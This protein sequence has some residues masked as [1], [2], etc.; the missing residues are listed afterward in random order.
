MFDLFPAGARSRLAE[1]EE[2]RKQE[3]SALLDLREEID[4]LLKGGG[5]L[6]AEE[7][8]TPHRFSRPGALAD[9]LGQILDRLK[10]TNEELALAHDE[11]R[12]IFDAAGAAILVLDDQ[13]RL[14]EWNRSGRDLFFP[15]REDARGLTCMHVVCGEQEPPENCLFRRVMVEGRKVE[16]NDFSAAGRH[17]NVAASPIRD[18]EGRISRVVLVY[19]DVAE[20]RR[21]EESLRESEFRFRDLLENASD[22]VQ[23]V[24][25]DGRLLYVNR[26]WRE[27]LGYSEEEVDTLDIFDL[28]HPQSREHCQAAFRQ[29]MEG[30]RFDHL[31]ACFIAR[32]GREV[33]VEGNLNCQL[34][35]GV[36]VATRG[37]FRDVTARRHA[38]AEIR[39]L[40]YFDV[41]TGLPNRTLFR[42]RL[43]Q[44]LARARR[45]NDVVALMFL[46]TDRFK[47]V[48]DSL[49]HEAGDRLLQA[50]GERLSACVRRSDTVARL[51]GDE[52]VII[53]GGIGG[54]HDA[55]GAAQKI[56]RAVSAPITV[57]GREIFLTCS[58]G[59]SLYPNDAGDPEEL[60]KNADLAMY[61]A[62][63]Q[64]N[65][66]QFFTPQMNVQ[67]L[68]RLVM[69]NDLRHALNRHE[70]LLHYQPQI[71]LSTG[72]IIGVEALLRWSHPTLGPV[73]PALF[74]DLAEETGLIVPVGRWVLRTACAQAQAWQ[75]AG[76][77]P[78]VMSVNLSAR[79]FREPD[80]AETV[81][82]TLALTG[83]PPSW[84]ELEITETALMENGERTC[85][86]LQEL[87]TMGV[88]LAVDDFGTGYSSLNYLKH[89]PIDRLKID[90]S[91][92]RDLTVNSE[93]AAI[94]EAIIAL[95]HTLRLRVIAEGVETREQL[96]FLREHRCD[97]M[98]GFYFCRP[99]TQEV[100]SNM[101]AQGLVCSD[102]CPI[103]PR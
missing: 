52:F 48:N 1:S 44:E 94:A 10:R 45:E 22:L 47:E 39:R 32:D 60:V 61:Q 92:V 63:G 59:I 4:L 49:G 99:E 20:R 2:L 82:E 103:D 46:D 25:S 15:D 101:L 18:S 40:A 68:E 90:R 102:I 23:S 33:L 13:M 6:P 98:Q 26:A 53:L 16:N 69:A 7:V 43:G 93:D 27:S 34:V 29:V 88:K 71:S 65:A 64:G 50:I 96:E 19:T 28:V 31:E 75:A 76:Y 54:E 100:F 58:I 72:Q 56:L 17:F 77:P 12:A 89:F 36:P 70:F 73:S 3:E 91:F 55:A 51:G 41:L 5:T 24:G 74:I 80:L 57:E 84:L 85:R 66:Y 78:L 9:T 21:A 8:D 87:K 83:L 81:R 79:Q 35:D 42:D 95:G 86:M 11:I 97:E 38:E 67:S 14:Q 30:G 37:I 62:K